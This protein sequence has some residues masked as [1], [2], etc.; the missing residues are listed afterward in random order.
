MVGIEGGTP[1]DWKFEELKQQYEHIMR[2]APS[3]FSPHGNIKIDD[4]TVLR[5]L[6]YIGKTGCKWEDLPEKFG[7]WNSIHKRYSDWETKWAMN[8]SADLIKKALGAIDWAALDEKHTLTKRRTLK[9]YAH[10]TESHEDS[11]SDADAKTE[12]K[13]SALCLLSL[14]M[15]PFESDIVTDTATLSEDKYPSSG[16]ASQQTISGTPSQQGSDVDPSIHIGKVSGK[17]EA[18]GRLHDDCKRFIVLAGST[19]NPDEATSLTHGAKKLREKLQDDWVIVDYKFV[20][21]YTFDSPT[22][23]T[24]VVCGYKR[25]ASDFWKGLK[26]SIGDGAE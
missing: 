19:I 18:K 21:D 7:N 1:I 15:N 6:Q 9:G 20:K 22:A 24:E 17:Y 23:A 11:A 3:V 26:K 25:N 4:L 8:D 10:K 16:T 5:A 2:S 12:F 14:A 13:D